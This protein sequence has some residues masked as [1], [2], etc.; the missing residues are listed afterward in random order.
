MG[1]GSH[2]VQTA[3]I[4]V[5]YDKILNTSKSNFCLVVG[6]VNS[7][8]ACAITAKKRNI[9]V[10]HVESGLRSNDLSMPEEINRIVTDSISDYHFVTSRNAIKNLRQSGVSAEQIFFVGNTMIDTLLQNS[11]DFKKPD[12][13]DKFALVPHRYLILTLHR[14][15]NVDKKDQLFSILSIISKT[16]KNRKVVFPTHPRTKLL[17][18]DVEKSFQT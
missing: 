5:E 17:L 11:E 10:G 7:T 3:K 18:T 8:L 13:F 12:F 4:M 15:S 16:A 1:S 2:A 9:K 14:P 6:D